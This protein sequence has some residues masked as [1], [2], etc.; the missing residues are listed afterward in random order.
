MMAR[1]ATTRSKPTCPIPSV[2][3]AFTILEFLTP[4]KHG[5]TI[6]ELS[7]IFGLPISTTSKLLYSLVYCGYLCRD[8]KGR[9]R[10]TTKVLQQGNELV[11]NMEL[12]E[13]AR[14]ELERLSRETGLSSTL[15]IRDGSIVVCIDKVEGASQI[16][17]AASVGKRF[18]LHA[19]APGK[20]LMCRLKEEDIEQVFGS[21]NLP[22]VTPNTVT[23]LS[24]F[25]RELQQV[26]SQGYAVDD[27]ENV[28]GIRGVAAPVFDHQGN[29]V[30]ALATGGVGFQ[31]DKN[32]QKVIAVVMST[33]A[34][35]S[36][37]LGYR[38]NKAPQGG[39]GAASNLRATRDLHG[40]PYAFHRE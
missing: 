30:A 31:L 33:S 21:A 38:G 32:I 28:V 4:R 17:I 35:V 16:R 1:P 34:A 13:V 40:H 10:T 7:R 29:V 12:R 15:S 26:R 5:H 36:E 18:H 20:A 11:A 23:S 3:K 25:Q 6:S 19:T 14:P 22:V 8:E 2:Q 27:G 9:F 37:K 24:Q 39:E